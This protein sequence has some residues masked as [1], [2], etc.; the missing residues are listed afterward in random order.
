MRKLV[1]G[2]ML[3]LDGV[4]Q[5]PGAPQEDP[6]RG[7]QFGGWTVPYWNDADDD[8][9]GQFMGSMF[10]A[11]FELLLGRKTYEIFA[12]YWPDHDDHPIGKAF[13]ATKKYVATHSREP[14]A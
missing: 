6:T 3:S 11:P 4:M 5:A 1:T 12:A 13:N 10:G 9:L 14:L 7:F 2:A 8:D